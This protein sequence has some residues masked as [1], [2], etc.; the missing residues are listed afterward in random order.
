[1]RNEKLKKQMGLHEIENT[2]NANICTIAVNPKEYFEKL[3]NRSINKKHKGVRCDT[4]GI[5]FESYTE[6]IKGLR[7]IDSEHI[8]KKL[9]QKRLQV[10][11][12][13]MRMTSVNKVQFASSNDKRYYVSAGI[14]YLPF[15]HPLLSDL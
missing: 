12:T 8:E 10:K 1:M 2:D 14:V 6:R 13:Q 11:N 15:G 5:I 9:V 7:E 4:P 3:K